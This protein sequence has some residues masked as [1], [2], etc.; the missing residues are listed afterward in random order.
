VNKGGGGQNC[1]S[2][3]RTRKSEN[4]NKWKLVHPPSTKATKSEPSFHLAELVVGDGVEQG[5]GV[6]VA[7]VGE[8]GVVDLVRQ[9][10]HPSLHTDPH[11]FWQRTVPLF[12]GPQHVQ[13]HVGFT[14]GRL[15]LWLLLRV[16][17]RRVL[18]VGG[19]VVVGRGRCT[20]VVRGRGRRWRVAVVGVVAEVHHLGRLLLVISKAVASTAAT[21]G[22]TVAAVPRRWRPGGA[23]RAPQWARLPRVQGVGCRCSHVVRAATA[24]T[25]APGPHGAQIVDEVAPHR[26][27]ACGRAAA[28]RRRLRQIIA[29]PVARGAPVV[30]ERGHGPGIQG[31]RKVHAARWRAP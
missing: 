21:T 28:L 3:V 2:A 13:E 17:R 23:R 4:I 10:G 7:L 1:G 22:S 25:A 12:D 9:L 16:V 18:V 27:A 6:H 24:A 14:R 19:L 26:L 20:V 5:R 8:R 11:R 15:L 31:L 30:Q 29:A